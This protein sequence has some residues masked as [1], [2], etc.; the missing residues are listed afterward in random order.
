MIDNKSALFAVKW[1]LF[2]IQCILRFV[3]F[4]W[5]KTKEKSGFAD[6]SGCENW[7]MHCIFKENLNLILCILRIE[8]L[9]IW[10]KL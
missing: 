3:T 4:L 5:Q 1:G 2:E 7:R 9:K 6:K 10:A 8:I